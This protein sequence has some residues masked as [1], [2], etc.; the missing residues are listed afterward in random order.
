MRLDLIIGIIASLIFHVGLLYGGELFK[1]ASKSKS[2]IVEKSYTQLMEMPKIEEEPEVSNET[3]SDVAAQVV[4]FAPPMQ[5][6]VPSLIT[7]DSFVQQIQPPPPEGLKANPGV[8]T[9][10]QNRSVGGGTKLTNV[11]NLADLDQ[12]PVPRAQDG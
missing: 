3:T 5:A 9:I 2:K 7:V 11:F 8:L 12:I 1:P 10:P 6:D 4:E